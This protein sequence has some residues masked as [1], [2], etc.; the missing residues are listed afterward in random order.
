[1]IYLAVKSC[2][3]L[4]SI[5]HSSSF[6]LLLL[7]IKKIEPLYLLNKWYKIIHL[8]RIHFHF[9]SLQ[10]NL[11]YV[12]VAIIKK[13]HHVQFVLTNKD[14][15]LILL[16]QSSQGCSYEGHLI[17]EWILPL[18]PYLP[19]AHTTYNVCWKHYFLTIH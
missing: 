16:L 19:Y 13:T 2:F 5:N 8:S 12:F 3:Q 11:L 17:N 7:F 9:I 1:M 4:L 18:L 10:Y 6:L 14:K 15:I